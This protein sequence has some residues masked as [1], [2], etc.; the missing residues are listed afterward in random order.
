MDS[1][2]GRAGV[3]LL[4]TP[5]CL[6]RDLRD[7]TLNYA[8]SPDLLSRYLLLKGTMDSVV[9]YIHVVYAPV[10]PGQ[11]PLLF[12]SL[13]RHFDDDAHHIALGD[14]NTVL[15]SQLDQARS[16]DRAR[17]QGREEL[18]DWMNELRLVDS[19]RLQHPDVQEFTSPT[20][21]S[22]ID[23]VFLDYR[24]F[25]SVFQDISHDFRAK[26]G[27]G[28]HIGLSFRFGSTYFKPPGR[29]P[30][31]CPSW[32]LKLPEAQAYLSDSLH[33][34]AAS[35]LPGI[36][37][38]NPG[39]LLDEHKKTGSIFLRELLHA[40]KNARQRDIEGLH[41]SINQLQRQEAL[42]PSV[43]LSAT[44]SSAK[45][46]LQT[47]LGE[48]AHFA[49]KQKFASDIQATERCS[50]FFF[51]P[52]QV[53]HKS[54]IPVDSAEALESTC[55]AFNSYCWSDINCSPSREYGHAKPN[56]NRMDLS[57]L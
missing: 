23:Y 45:A 46:A 4:L 5:T 13:P 7:V 50:K 6:V 3:G 44:L 43:D 32:V 25:C 37:N 47:K 39:C 53:L 11:R 33:K 55:S 24:L 36:W 52:P 8:S 20:G 51:R 17:R 35:F 34:L 26:S 40:K 28:D 56:W 16:H 12:T 57:R 54:P 15:S 49:S 19:W 41:L 14:F 10:Q 27:T 29:A 22:R 42:D 2:T 38:Y 18:L 1:Y 9:T 31:K 48:S 30:W 21:T